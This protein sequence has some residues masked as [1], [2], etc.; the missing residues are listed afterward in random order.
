MEQ[1]TGDHTGT[2]RSKLRIQRESSQ[3]TRFSRSAHTLELN[4][5]QEARRVQ[6]D[7]LHAIA[8]KIELNEEK[9]G[10]YGSARFRRSHTYRA[11][12][13]NGSH[14]NRPARSRRS[15]NS[16]ELTRRKRDETDRHKQNIKNRHGGT[17]EHRSI[18]YKDS[19]Q[20]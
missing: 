16:A 5:E 8:E 9:S 3:T 11:A 20:I 13:R 15:G 10:E 19:S 17:R 7:T 4:E 6:I 14:A 2:L 12:Q 18:H 1:Q